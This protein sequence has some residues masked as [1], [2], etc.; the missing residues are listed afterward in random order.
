MQITR[1]SPVR[2]G[3]PRR[4]P[5]ST[6]REISVLSKES[7]HGKIAEDQLAKE[8]T[9]EDKRQLKLLERQKREDFE[10]QRK[11][12]ALQRA[13]DLVR[14]NRVPIE[15]TRG[16]KVARAGESFGQRSAVR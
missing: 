6:A 10:Q 15:I 14:S 8:F 9:R 2:R 12:A 16:A 4:L 3:E 11:D 13:A 7:D 1:P 5:L